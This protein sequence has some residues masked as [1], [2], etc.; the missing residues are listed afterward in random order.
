M[1]NQRMVN[2]IDP[3]GP[4]EL[5][6]FIDASF[7][8]H[9]RLVDQRISELRRLLRSKS[10]V[11]LHAALE[12]LCRT[13]RAARLEFGI[14]ASYYG[15]DYEDQARHFLDS[16]NLAAE[17]AEQTDYSEV[18][19][20]LRTHADQVGAMHMQMKVDAPSVVD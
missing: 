6:S 17:L 20:S 10:K 14:I 5:A 4:A 12:R 16:V 13:V 19:D 8:L 2:G 1:E 3:H 9:T 11:Q 7:E 18:R 15:V